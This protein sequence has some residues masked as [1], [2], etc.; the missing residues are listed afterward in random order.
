MLLLKYRLYCCLGMARPTD[1]EV[2]AIE[3]AVC[4][5]A[6]PSPQGPR[7][8]GRQ[9]W[10]GGNCGKTLL[11]SLCGEGKGQGSR[12]SSYSGLWD[13]GVPSAGTGPWADWWATTGRACGKGG[14]W[15]VGSG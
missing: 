14:S 5:S 8:G 9:E 15:C 10:G 1:E 6:F 2:I 4:C 7:G 12:V 13:T 11:C 3:K